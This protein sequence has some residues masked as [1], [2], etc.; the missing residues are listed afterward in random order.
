MEVALKS[1]LKGGG[2]DF[3]KGMGLCMLNGMREGLGGWGGVHSLNATWF[4]GRRREG[5]GRGGA[6]GGRD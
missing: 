3:L 2:R 4:K 1:S 6:L 5:E